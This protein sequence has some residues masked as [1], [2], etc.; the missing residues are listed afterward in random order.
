MVSSY[1]LPAR[2]TPSVVC[3]YWSGCKAKMLP[4]L[5]VRECTI[6]KPEVGGSFFY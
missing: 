3:S 2:D 6:P 1:Q 4:E 5:C